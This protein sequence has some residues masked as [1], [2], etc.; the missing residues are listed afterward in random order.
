M[1]K[2]FKKKKEDFICD[3]CFTLVIGDGYTN[4]C[5]TCLWSKHVDQ[6]PGDRAAECGG[7]MEPVGVEIKEGETRIIHKCTRC[8]KTLPNRV[9]PDDNQG[10]ITELSSKPN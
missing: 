8:G 9:S 3:Y 4:H 6:S 7:A 10:I 1:P 5:P 2:H